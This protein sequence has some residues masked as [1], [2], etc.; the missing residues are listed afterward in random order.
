M[1]QEAKTPQ[2]RKHHQRDHQGPVRPWFLP[3]RA[4]VGKNPAM[5]ELLQSYEDLTGSDAKIKGYSLV[6]QKPGDETQ[7]QGSETLLY[8]W[9][10]LD[11]GEGYA[12]TSGDYA[13]GRLHAGKTTWAD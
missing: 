10:D 7:I 8:Y 2:H 9:T 6:V 4:H 11:K 12:T 13:L 3:A 5:I 1:A